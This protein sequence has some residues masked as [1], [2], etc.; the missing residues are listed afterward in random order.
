MSQCSWS[1]GPLLHGLSTTPA[2]HQPDP[3]ALQ[4]TSCTVHFPVHHLSPFLS[5]GVMWELP[6]GS[7]R[8]TTQA[9]LLP[10]LPHISSNHFSSQQ[11]SKCST[12]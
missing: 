1:F 12:P 11:L 10:L 6:H 4:H 3:T 7:N 9:H 2:G 8:M 5:R